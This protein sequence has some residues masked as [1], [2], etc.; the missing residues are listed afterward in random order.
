MVTE[1]VILASGAS[2]QPGLNHL[3]SFDPSPLLSLYSVSPY[4]L[5]PGHASIQ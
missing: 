2:I 4:I 1:V 3:V 5:Y